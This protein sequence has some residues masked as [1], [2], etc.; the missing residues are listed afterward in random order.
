MAAARRPDVH[1]SRPLA[2]HGSGAGTQPVGHPAHRIAVRDRPPL[3][4]R[5]RAGAHLRAVIK[6]LCMSR[7]PLVL[8]LAAV[9]ATSALVPGVAQAEDLLQTYELARTGDPQFAAAEIDPQAIWEGSVQARSALLPQIGADATLTRSRTENV[10][11]AAIQLP[12]GGTAFGDIE[13]ESTTRSMGVSVSQMIYDHRNITRLRSANALSRASD[14]LLESQSDTL[15]T[16]TSAAYFEALVQLENLAAAEAA[17]AALKKQFDFASKR[18]EVGL[19]PITDVHEA[20]AQYDNAPANTILARHTLE[21]G[22]PAL[23]EVTGAPVDHLMGLPDPFQASLPE[24]TG[25]EQWVASAIETNPALQAKQFQ[26]QSAEA[27][28]S[29]ARAGHYPPLYLNGGYGDTKRWGGTDFSGDFGSFDT[30]DGE[31]HGRGP[32]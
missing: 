20:R 30:D 3:P 14:Y 27:N 15:I 18:L 6:G 32:Q 24:S 31:D 12:G 7:H 11:E 10:H 19:A 2:G 16:R 9:I 28:V 23:R 13:S 29:T 25:V 8:A 26:V 1:R 5:R 21:D 17:E 22:Y 4:R